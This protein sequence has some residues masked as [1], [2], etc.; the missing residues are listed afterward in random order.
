MNLKIKNITSKGLNIFVE[1]NPKRLQNDNKCPES[2]ESAKRRYNS[3][4]FG[5]ARDRYE[6]LTEKVKEKFK[7]EELRSTRINP[8]A[9]DARIELQ[10][11][12]SNEVVGVLHCLYRMRIKAQYKDA[13]YLGFNLQGDY[14]QSMSKDLLKDMI[15]ITNKTFTACHRYCVMRTGNDEILKLSDMEKSSFDISP[16]VLDLFKI[17]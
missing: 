3:F 5:T 15:D 16:T 13:V 11:L 14:Y 4:L 6:N 2:I 1:S 12:A 8:K 9:K 17:G 10:R 7:V